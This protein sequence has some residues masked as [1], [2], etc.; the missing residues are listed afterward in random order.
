VLFSTVNILKPHVSALAA[1]AASPAHSSRSL[2]SEFTPD[3]TPISSSAPSEVDPTEVRDSLTDTDAEDTGNA[4]NAAAEDIGNATN[5]TEGATESEG[6]EKVFRDYANACDRVKNFYA[7]QHA[8]QTMEYNL[9][10]RNYFHEREKL[11]M[12]V[13]EAIER[14]N[15]LVDD[16]DPDVRAFLTFFLFSH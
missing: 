9:K 1:A 6:D 7:E 2:G 3:I 8:K 10:A 4:S 14:L 16:S 13:W 15:T 12:G 11:R 5:A